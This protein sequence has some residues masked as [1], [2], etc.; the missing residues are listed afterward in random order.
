MSDD[1]AARAARPDLSETPLYQDFF[2]HHEDY[3]RI[4]IHLVGLVPRFASLFL[5]RALTLSLCLSLA[6]SLA[7]ICWWRHD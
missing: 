6:H 7:Q 4:H 5:S 1:V 3:V 2:E